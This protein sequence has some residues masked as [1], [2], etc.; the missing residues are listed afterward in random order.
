VHRRRGIAATPARGAR[1]RGWLRHL[2]AV[3]VLGVLVWRLGTGPFTAGLGR[4]DA[5][6]LA[7]ASGMAV[8]TTLCCAWRWTLVARGLG[9]AVPLRT[10]V[11]ACYRSQFLNLTMPSGVLGDVDRAVRHGRAVGDRGLG[12]RS[13]V[14]ER[15][16]GQAVLVAGAGC[17]LLL[18]P[19][20]VRQGARVAG[21]T[22]VAGTLVVG[23]LWGVLH[24]WPLPVR[25][26]SQAPGWVRTVKGAGAELRAVLLAR[27]TRSRILLASV[28]AMCGH[29]VTFLFAARTAGSGAAP[30]TV[31]P[32]ALVVLLAMG[33][34]NVAGWGPREG[35]AAWVFGA[36]GLGAQ[37]GVTT[38]VV[39]GVMVFAGALPGAFVIL[40][41]GLKRAPGVGHG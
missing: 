31:L 40:A 6:S 37:E 34:P 21:L 38:A 12:L 29:V 9:V 20:P 25:P 39:Y 33:L 35:I 26:M 30:L 10:A 2:A 41:A 28:V 22:V 7:T 24:R 17:A 18:L 19:S 3:G 4:V 1:R 11:A 15:F 27:H 14:G 16:A 8:V 32:L 23:L 13:V 36:A 5:A